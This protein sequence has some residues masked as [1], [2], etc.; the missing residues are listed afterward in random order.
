VSQYRWV[1]YRLGQIPEVKLNSK[2][3]FSSRMQ[4]EF[5]GL[6]WTP[7]TEPNNPPGRVSMKKSEIHG[8]RENGISKMCPATWLNHLFLGYFANTSIRTNDEQYT[9]KD[10]VAMTIFRLFCFCR[11]Y[12]LPLYKPPIGKLVVYIKKSNNL[13]IFIVTLSLS[14]C[15]YTSIHT[16]LTKNVKLKYQSNGNTQCPIVL[17]ESPETGRRKIIYL[18]S[19]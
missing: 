14:T 10:N 2:V 11:N 18:P 5:L 6:N 4:I 3:V 15:L 12:Q 1:H 16:Y 13:T 7:L 19:N 17:S 8:F 9:R